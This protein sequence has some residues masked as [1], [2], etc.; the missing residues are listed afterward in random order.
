MTYIIR[1]TAI[2][3]TPPNAPLYDPHC[4]KIEITDDSG[5]EYL[6]ITQVGIDPGDPIK[7]DQDEW[8]AIQQAISQLIS[9][10]QPP[11]E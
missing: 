3:V 8:P 5:G 6:T 1:T 11:K 4:T 7:I 9:T 2:T 10:I